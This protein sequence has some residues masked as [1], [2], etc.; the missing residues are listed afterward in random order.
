MAKRGDGGGAQDI[1]AFSQKRKDW[2]KK[3]HRYQLGERS[4]AQIGRCRLLRSTLG[5]QQAQLSSASHGGTPWAR[6]G[7]ASRS[8]T[9]R[10]EVVA[11]FRLTGSQG[12][13]VPPGSA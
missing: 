12:D 9:G 6:R 2:G 4:F 7:N 8:G 13:G 10:S 11:E 5:V 3:I 1:P